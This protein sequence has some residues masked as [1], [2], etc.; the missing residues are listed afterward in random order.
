M[1]SVRHR[2]Q[3][4]NHLDVSG[5]F[6]PLTIRGMSLRNRFVMPGMGRRAFTADTGAP[7][8]ELWAYFA[9]RAAGE[10]A[11]IITGA[12][13]VDHP[14]AT[15]KPHHG[16][17][18]EPTLDAWAGCVKAVRDEGGEILIQLWHEGALRSEEGSGPL[19][20]YPTISPS[21]LVSPERAN[22][23]AATSAELE[24]LRDAFVRSALMAADV[25]AS[26]IELHACHGY[27]LDQ[28]LWEKTNRRTDG[29]GGTAIE[30]RARLHVEIIE[31]IRRRAPVDFVISVRFSQWKEVDYDAKIVD[32]P[33][34]LGRLVALF[35]GAG[36]DVIHASARRFW[37]PE[38]PGS[39][40][41]IAGWTKSMSSVPVIAVGSVGL[42]GDV[43][44]T[45]AGA[46]PSATGEAG[47]HELV[48]RFER[49]EFDLVSVG[50][51]QLGD[52]QWVRKVRE[53]RIGDIRPY[54]AED[55]NSAREL[56]VF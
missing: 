15:Q 10:C 1:R 22:G 11:L 26:G 4:T 8:P 12:I 51:S 41:G 20:H 43:M 7:M 40:L 56:P 45:L 18:T 9:R 53:G 14:S 48:A 44:D 23:R 55:R 17:I 47:L 13:A 6:E 2:R 54:S 24:E 31:A 16:W 5:L 21:G 3:G 29:Y 37:S 32:T 42:D 52:A 36:A 33:E 50:R 25:G 35:E 46:Q 28:F 39:E 27:L 49:G 19:A 30:S 38:W 34:E